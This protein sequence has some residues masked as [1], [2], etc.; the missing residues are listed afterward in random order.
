MP[1][2]PPGVSGL[3]FS[4]RR[5]P[6]PPLRPPPSAAVLCPT[7]HT[8]QSDGGDQNQK[9]DRP[10]HPRGNRPRAA[11][12]RLEG[13]RRGQR[14]H[15]AAAAAVLVCRQTTGRRPHVSRLWC[16]RRQRP[17]S[18]VVPAWWC[19]TQLVKPVKATSQQ[20]FRSIFFCKRMRRRSNK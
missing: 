4:G 8:Q 1:A 12:E 6:S 20:A 9:L 11:G 5:H 18:C 15:S 3:S 2:E 14:G 17:P 19:P 16:G 7:P 10:H 13:G